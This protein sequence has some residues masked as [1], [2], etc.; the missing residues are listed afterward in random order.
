MIDNDRDKIE[1]VVFLQ[2]KTPISAGHKKVMHIL[3]PF[4]VRCPP[5]TGG[6]P[7]RSE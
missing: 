6:R 7:R 4:A 2:K 3:V 5:Q 1:V